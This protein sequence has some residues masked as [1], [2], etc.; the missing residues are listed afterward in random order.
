[1][2][3]PLNSIQEPTLVKALESVN[4]RLRALESQVLLN[5]KALS[6]P[7]DWQ[8]ASYQNSWVDYSGAYPGARYA[9]DSMGFVILSGVVKNGTVPSVIFTLP[10]GYRPAVDLIFSVTAGAPTASVLDVT[11]A[12]EVYINFGTNAY[13][14][15]EGVRFQA[16]Q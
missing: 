14:L 6:A 9:I 1:M 4:S 15:L 11:A 12:G 13:V 8:A 5:K 3:D 10:A 7:L 2:I 16:A